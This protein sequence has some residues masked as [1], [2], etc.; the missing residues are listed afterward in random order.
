MLQAIEPQNTDEEENHLDGDGDCDGENP[1]IMVM[2]MMHMLMLPP[3]LMLMTRFS[4]VIMSTY[5]IDEA[6]PCCCIVGHGFIQGPTVRF[7]RPYQCLKLTVG[8]DDLGSACIPR[9]AST[10]VLQG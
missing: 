5:L 9:Y 8:G 2:V 6:L 3:T 4:I 10:A 7:I 1:L